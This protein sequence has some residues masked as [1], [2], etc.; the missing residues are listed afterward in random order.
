MLRFKFLEKLLTLFLENFIYLHC[1]KM[2]ECGFSPRIFPYKDRINSVLIRENIAQIKPIFCHILHSARAAIIIQ[3][4][5]RLNYLGGFK[6]P[7]FVFQQHFSDYILLKSYTPEAATRDVPFHNIHRKTLVLESVFNKVTGLKDCNFIKKRLQYR[8][9]SVYIPKISR[10]RILKNICER[11]LL[12]LQANYLTFLVSCSRVFQGSQ[13][14][15]T[16]RAFEL[17]KLFIQY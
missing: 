3:N 7:K 14:L 16:A 2:A 13:I 12:T 6:L 17:W 1:V 15:K 11:L 4:I 5:I 9:F 10:T 8:C